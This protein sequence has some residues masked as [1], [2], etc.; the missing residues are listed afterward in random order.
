MPKEFTVNC[1][2]SYCNIPIHIVRF[3]PVLIISNRHCSDVKFID[4]WSIRK[5]IDLYMINYNG[6][7]TSSDQSQTFLFSDLSSIYICKKFKFV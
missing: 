7:S 3:E 6:I 4:H 2:H 5:S 1:P